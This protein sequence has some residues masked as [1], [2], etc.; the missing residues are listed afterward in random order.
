MWWQRK[1]GLSATTL[2]VDWVSARLRGNMVAIVGLVD[3]RWV[4]RR[5]LGV[6]YLHTLLTISHSDC[7][8]HCHVREHI[9]PFQLFHSLSWRTSQWWR[10][11]GR[12]VWMLMVKGMEEGNICGVDGVW[13]LK[14]QTNTQ[15]RRETECI[16]AGTCVQVNWKLENKISFCLN[17]I[18]WCFWTEVLQDLCVLQHTVRRHLCS[19]QPWCCVEYCLRDVKRCNQC[20]LSI[21]PH[22]QRD[23][24]WQDS[25]VYISI[26]LFCLSDKLENYSADTL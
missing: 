17:L 18:F 2:Q 26:D 9:Q 14:E 5:A 1:T 11:D 7:I 23:Q 15:P 24:C 13:H 19:E 21:C 16:L 3:C 20:D 12:H 25:P 8:N 4:I 6:S 10:N 22:Q